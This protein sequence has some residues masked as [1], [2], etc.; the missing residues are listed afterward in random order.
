M[1]EKFVI[2]QLNDNSYSAKIEKYGDYILV[3]ED[4]EI[5]LNKNTLFTFSS[6]P[7]KIITKSK[8]RNLLGYLNNSI[9]YTEE[10]YYQLSDSLG[11]HRYIVTN[12]DDWS[13]DDESFV[14]Q[15]KFHKDTEIQYETKEIIQEHPFIIVPINTTNK[16]IKPVVKYRS[17][18]EDFYIVTFHINNI[19]HEVAKKYGFHF[20]ETNLGRDVQDTFGYSHSDSGSSLKFKGFYARNTSL[21][22]ERICYKTYPGTLEQCEE[23]YKRIYELVEKE[24]VLAKSK[25]IPPPIDSLNITEL[26]ENILRTIT[27]VQS[28][29][30]N[31]KNEFDYRAAMNTL[32]KM[33]KDIFD[34]LKSKI[35]E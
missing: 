14:K 25:I 17:E 8:V 21:D 10:D 1:E 4:R 27:K 16:W 32:N 24:F 30:Y 22:K 35:D 6:K 34:F 13:G 3:L 23:E 7:L 29:S 15:Y 11:F 18:D 33:K 31:K 12:R 20:E 9:L 26:Y 19:I 2:Y 5:L 28:V